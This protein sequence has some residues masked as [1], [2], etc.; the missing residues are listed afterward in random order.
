MRRR[1][2][3]TGGFSLLELMIA[4]GLLTVIIIALYA[5]FDQT[6]K[7]F[8]QSLNQADLSEGG[9]S[10][11]DLMVRNLERAA[12]PQVDDALHL[13]LRPA[14]AN[15]YELV[16]AGEAAQ[17]NRTQP[18]RF[19]E[20]FFTYPAGGGR[21]HVAGLFI[22]TLDAGPVTSEPVPGLGSLYL[23]TRPCPTRIWCR[24]ST[25]RGAS[26]SPPRV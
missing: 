21:W 14:N 20:L 11:L 19:D 23:T 10:A 1:P 17:A 24:C 15:G 3:R 25:V 22:G 26:G 18:L 2:R 6:Q 5:M 7:A 12:S 16:F 8:R 9:R 4:V 13:V